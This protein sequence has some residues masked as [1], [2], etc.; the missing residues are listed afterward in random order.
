[1]RL[2]STKPSG[3]AGP[4]A[5]GR[6]R[7][8]FPAKA[9][10]T[11]ES[12]DG[13]GGSAA[14][15]AY[16]STTFDGLV[17]N[18]KDISTTMPALTDIRH[19]ASAEAQVAALRRLK[20]ELVGQGKRK[21]TLVCDGGIDVVVDILSSSEDDNARLQ[22][23][24]IVAT[25]AN[26]GPAFVS[27]LLAANAPQVLLDSLAHDTPSKRV[28]ASLQALR[29]I[30]AAWRASQESPQQEAHARLDLFTRHS[31]EV[32]HDLLRQSPPCSA[33]MQHL[34]L[35]TDLITL[36][37][38]SETKKAA[39]SQ[40]P[41][42]EILTALLVS[43]TVIS[44]LVTWQAE[45]VQLPPPPQ[46]S[47]VSHI[48]SAICTVVEGS[49][50]RTHR[51]FLSSTVRALFIG[52]SWNNTDERHLFSAR[53]GFANTGEPLLPVLHIP[54]YGTTT[55][56]YGSRAFPAMAALQSKHAKRGNS[57]YVTF[58][59]N[60]APG[61]DM[62]HANAVC[63]WL[64]L[65]S[66]SAAGHGRLVALRLLA[67]V[68]NSVD[69]MDSSD[70][71]VGGHRT[72]YTQK[73]RERKKQIAVL[74]VPLA[75]RMVQIANES[76]MA[77]GSSSAQHADDVLVKEQACEI[78]ALLIRDFDELQI[79]A[80]DA[81][82]IK[83]V[84]PLLK[85]TFD[86]VPLAK[87]MWS[88]RTASTANPADLPLTR[89]LGSRGLPSEILHA[90]RC[91][92]S[93]LQALAALAEKEDIHRKA[94]VEAG[95]VPCI[96][97]ALKPF[98]ADYA[99]TLAKNRGQVVGPKDGNTTAVLLAACRAAK[100]MSRSVSLLRT[101]L[102]DAGIAKPVFQLLHHTDPEVQLAA[103]D[104]CINLLLEF[105]PMREDL[106]A[107]GVVKTLADHARRSEPALRVSSLWAL[108]HLVSSS[109]KEIK[110]KTI[111]ELG[112]G[113]L[114]GVI[115]GEHLHQRGHGE[116]AGGGV[117]VAGLSTPN[118]AGE[119]VD[120]LNPSSTG[121]DV[122]DPD[123][124]QDYDEE[125]E[126]I[127]DD[128]DGEVMYDELSS[129]H[130]QA[131]QLRSTIQQAP[132]AF[133]SK[134]YLSSV[135]EIE[136]NPSLRAR[137]DDVAVQ[138]QALDFIRNLLNGEDCAAM[139]EYLLQHIGSAKIFELLT[140]K[141]ARVTDTGSSTSTRPV[142][143]PSALI[144]STVN[145]LTH[146]ANA[147]PR[148]K[149]LLIAQKPLL[150]AWLPHFSHPDRKVRVACV[151]AIN[152]LTWIDDDSDRRDA[153]ARA[154][155]LRSCGI[156]TAVRQLIGDGDLDVKERAKTAVRQFEQL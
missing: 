7:H 135:R 22:A 10:G 132:S 145:I 76:K 15:Q 29:N 55:Y 146:I 58:D 94:I 13:G 51:F 100:T 82:A 73:N 31:I 32:F 74:G 98:P 151:W 131:S 4:R 75:A 80:V 116:V 6:C 112:T 35:I 84:C 137:Q 104:V 120:L 57:H 59:E 39:L 18:C 14:R 47:S 30:A 140:E 136:Q 133:N 27:P 142:Y 95:V 87:P 121:M 139:F 45:G 41:L 77:E 86:P 102:I 115:R 147:L 17:L 107:E 92:Q 66:R 5:A 79:A 63:S 155:E 46:A 54:A 1:M 37:V 143:G 91:R 122:D 34:R 38:I 50:Y 103:T 129:T 111:E 12:S 113:W 90:M 9:L 23:T 154:Q 64:L 148:H 114:V 96:F 101:S 83:Y 117:S 81:G 105:S 49:A 53:Q 65:L 125:E 119:Q 8:L 69:A 130:Y 97:D 19:A 61:G 134:R 153:R 71:I 62:D 26:G 43:H 40:S 141:L 52:Q 138:E 89:Q 124:E 24:L 21:E 44:G 108:K 72:E 93:A 60:L 123:D 109:P 36:S 11:A 156:E 149:Q 16:R 85:K 25:I 68:N 67:L 144:I 152:S 56:H 126:V 3:E 110:V 127:N 118:A 128:E 99:E 78:L 20:N 106:I 28:T 33:R 70:A 88:A 2:C 42:F 48:I 150:Q